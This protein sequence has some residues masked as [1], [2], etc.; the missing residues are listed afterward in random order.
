MCFLCKWSILIS[1]DG[2]VIYPDQ[3][4]LL[5]MRVIP[6][7]VINFKRFHLMKI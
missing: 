5:E 4:I 1:D 6:L 7:R 3:F 2:T